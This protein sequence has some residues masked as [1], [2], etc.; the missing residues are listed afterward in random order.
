VLSVVFLLLAGGCG[1]LHPSVRA[2]QQQTAADVLDGYWCPMHP[3]V[4][5]SAA[6]KCPLCAMD[7]VVIRPPAIDEYHMDVAVLPGAARRGASGLRLVLREPLNNTPVSD[8]VT[9]HEKPL[10]LFMVSRDLEYFAHVH[11]EP[12]A[13]GSFRLTH[14]APPGEYVIIAD[15][16]PTNGTAQMVHRAIATPGLDRPP[17]HTPTTNLRPDIPDATAIAAGNATRGS[18]EKTVDGTRIRLEGADLIAGQIGLLRFHLSNAADGTAIS[19]LE[20]YLGA[21][22]HMLMT[23]STLTDSVHGHPEETDTRI[24]A[25]TFRP[26]LPPPGVSKLWLQFQRSG[27]LTTVPFVIDVQE[28]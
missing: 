4:R 10:H 17:A 21:P 3:S 20:P 9:V 19:D 25:I 12:S 14:E 28:P 22:G 23:N 8:L 1:L 13:N 11:P 2:Q 18:V 15:F 7:L 26:L 5:S 24:S 27:K 16:L 6:G